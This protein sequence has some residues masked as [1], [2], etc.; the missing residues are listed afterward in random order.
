MRFPFKK[1]QYVPVATEGALAN[2]DMKMF[3]IDGHHVAVARLQDGYHAFDDVCTHMQCSLAKGFLKGKVVT[4]PCHVSQFDVTTGAVVKGPATRP[5]K[6]YA[7][8]VEEGSIQV[9]L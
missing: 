6:S 5:V 9:Q 7:V 1:R 2:G 4:C 3:E 8:K